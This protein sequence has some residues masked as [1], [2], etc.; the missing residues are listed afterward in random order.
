M[1]LK[2]EIVVVRCGDCKHYFERRFGGG[3]I[4]AEGQHITRPEQVEG[5]CLLLEARR[6]DTD[7]SMCGQW[8]RNP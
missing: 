2:S 1:E 8:E 5:F 7:E 3:R 4:T 6:V